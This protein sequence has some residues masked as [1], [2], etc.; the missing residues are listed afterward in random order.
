[1]SS[2]PELIKLLRDS[3][4]QSERSQQVKI[5]PSELG[6]CRRR[7]WYKLHN[8]PITNENVLVLSA[9]MGTAIHSHIQK[10]LETADPQEERFLTEV[11]VEADGMIGHIDLYDKVNKE[12]IDWKSTT[13]KNIGYF[14]SQQQRWQVQTYGYLLAANGYEVE[15]VTLVA[16][17]RDGDERDIVYHS[18]RYEPT[19]ANEALAWLKDVND[20]TDAPPPEKD[21]TFCKHYCPYFDET[22]VFGC[23]GRGKADAPEAVLIEDPLVDKAAQEYLDYAKAIKVLEAKQEQA[24]AMLEGHNGQ[25]LNGFKVKW[26]VTAGRTSVDEDEVLKALGFVPK[27]TGRESYRLVV[28]E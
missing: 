10:I 1:M 2:V 14:P 12:V 16:M 17:S 13:K 7:T 24:R 6:G 9:F 27:K 20:S 19:V 22:G 8:Q 4:K 25:T 15:K 21:A 3:S 18:E 26:S 28:K 11:E 5:G 23:V